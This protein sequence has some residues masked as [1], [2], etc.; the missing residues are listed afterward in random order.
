I[1]KYPVEEL[2]FSVNY[3]SEEGGRVTIYVYNGGKKNIP[4][5]ISDKIIKNELNSVKNEIRRVAEMGYYQNLKEVK[6]DTVT[7]GGAGGKV[8][9]LRTAYNLSAGGRDLTSEIYI[10]AH[11]NRFIKI[12]AT[13]PRDKDESGNKAM[14][15]LLAQIDTMFSK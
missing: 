13:R 5:D 9:A 12:R 2:G 1:Q 15:N 14:N 4:D 8:K 11:Q 3:E 10:F 7:L 6:N